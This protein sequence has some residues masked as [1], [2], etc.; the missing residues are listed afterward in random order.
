MRHHNHLDFRRPSELDNSD[1]R[2]LRLVNFD[3]EWAWLP[4]ETN[5]IARRASHLMIAFVATGPFLS[6]SILMS[7]E[8]GLGN[9]GNGALPAGLAGR[10]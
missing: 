9:D 4:A 2:V 6:G 3:A 8:H 5:K 10:Q 7:D 1:N